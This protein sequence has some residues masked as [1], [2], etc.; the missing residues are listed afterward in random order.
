MGQIYARHKE[1]CMIIQQYINDEECKYNGTKDTY[2]EAKYVGPAF[3]KAIGIEQ[4]LTDNECAKVLEKI[5]VTHS[6]KPESCELYIRCKSSKDGKKYCRV[7]NLSRVIQQEAFDSI[8]NKVKQDG[9]YHDNAVS[10]LWNGKKRYDG[11]SFDDNIKYYSA[12]TMTKLL[13]KKMDNT[14]ANDKNF[15]GKVAHTNCYYNRAEQ[16]TECDLHLLP[17]CVLDAMFKEKVELEIT[18]VQE[19]EELIKQ[20]TQVD[21]IESTKL[22]RSLGFMSILF[23]S[24]FK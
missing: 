5:L 20:S 16:R 21:N 18:Q 2:P 12:K 19:N 24:I 11:F 10:K 4:T 14:I 8:W 6:Y 22:N 13:Q 17:K 15:K 3:I 7:Y 23:P 1:R 9:Y